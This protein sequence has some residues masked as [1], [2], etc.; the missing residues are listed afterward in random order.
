MFKKKD[1]KVES[2][3]PEF[4][5]SV[6]LR[7][8]FEITA[9]LGYSNTKHWP[10]ERAELDIQDSGKKFLDENLN[11]LVVLRTYG[12]AGELTLSG[13]RFLLEPGSLILFHHHQ[14]RMH[15]TVRDMWEFDWFEFSVSRTEIPVE[16]VMMFPYKRSERLARV[17]L[18]GLFKRTPDDIAIHGC[19][20]Y[21]LTLWISR[22]RQLGGRVKDIDLSESLSYIHDNLSNK[23][24]VERLAEICCVSSRYFRALFAQKMKL[25]PTAYINNLRLQMGAELLVNT[26]KD[27]NEIAEAVGLS[28]A[29]YFSVRFKKHFGIAPRN[30]RKSARKK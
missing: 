26:D 7:R 16:Q 23:I 9:D 25:P 22:I 10:A 29:Y 2:A 6:F 5:P 28:D 4:S 20:S 14:P 8:A 19:F 12:G 30:Y 27:L 3:V 18:F 11:N 15:R 21:L 13:R 24:S 1:N 17:A